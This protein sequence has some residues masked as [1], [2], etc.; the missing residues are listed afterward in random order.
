MNEWKNHLRHVYNIWYVHITKHQHIPDRPYDQWSAPEEW[1]QM[2]RHQ[3][4]HWTSQFYDT[5]DL[6]TC[7]H[8]KNMN[9]VIYQT[10]FIS[11]KPMDDTICNYMTSIN[12]G[13]CPFI[14]CLT[15]AIRNSNVVNRRSKSIITLVSPSPCLHSTTLAFWEPMLQA[16][17]LTTVIHRP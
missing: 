10:F 9:S 5:Q 13:S 6:C 7:E 3:T 1:F 4:F 11:L 16:Q 2:R 15:W 17:N 12:T 14:L 8:S